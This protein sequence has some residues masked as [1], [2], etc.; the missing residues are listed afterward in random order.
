MGNNIVYTAPCTENKG[1]GKC[2]S[3]AEGVDTK[4]PC[5]VKILQRNIPS[6]LDEP[7]IN[8]VTERGE[9]DVILFS[10]PSNG[11]EGHE[12][13]GNSKL[14]YAVSEMQ[15]WRSHMEDAHVLN[16]NLA[17]NSQQ[18]M[19]IKDH[20]LFAVFDGHGGSFASKFCGKHLVSTLTAQKDWQAYLTLSSEGYKSSDSVKGLKFLKSALTSTFLELD[21]KLIEAQ[22]KIRLDQLS[23]L[24]NLVYSVGGDLAHPIFLK[25]TQEHEKIMNFDRQYPSLLPPGINLERSGSTGVVVLITPSHI[26]CA[27]AG[28]SRAILSKKNK[29]LPLSFDHKP[30]NDVELTRVEKDG[31]FVRNGRVDGDLAVSRSF[32]D[33]GYKF[34]NATESGRTSSEAKDHRVTVHPDILVYAREPSNDEFLV[35]ACDGIWDRLSNKQCSDLVHSLVYCEGETDVGL[36]CE[37]MIDTALELD[38]RDNMTCCIVIF[39]GVI[40]GVADHLAMS[41]RSKL[42]VMKRRLDRETMWGKHSTPAMRHRIRCEEH[43]IQCDDRRKK[44]QALQQAKISKSRPHTAAGKKYKASNSYLSINGRSRHS[45]SLKLNQI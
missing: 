45:K 9:A 35:L 23:Q 7:V 10:P 20:H 27:N 22:R 32:G 4:K 41:T 13:D 29:V 16:P 26:I 37:E 43:R 17:S 19:L 8:K 31:G 12:G 18:A 28:D 25:G 44:A 21:T 42:G 40:M 34:G 14:R 24:E 36:I 5:V 38:S 6:F 30:S 3:V 39:P 1:V 15:G 2:S 11:R 33:F